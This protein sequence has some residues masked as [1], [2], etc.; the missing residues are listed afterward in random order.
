MIALAGGESLGTQ[1]SRS[2]KNPI[3][4]H[5]WGNTWESLLEIISE[6]LDPGSMPNMWNWSNYMMASCPQLFTIGGLTANHSK[7]VAYHI[8]LLGN[9]LVCCL[10]PWTGRKNRHLKSARYFVQ[11]AGHTTKAVKASEREVWSAVTRWAKDS[12]TARSENLKS[13]VDTG[14][15]LLYGP[16]AQAWWHTRFL[17]KY[18]TTKFSHC[19]L[20]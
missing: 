1:F 4:K 15:L 20:Q 14:H 2:C 3:C 13:N 16:R 12:N 18:P 19:T 6:G 9:W 7:A 10:F 5:I 8:S 11:C 17:F